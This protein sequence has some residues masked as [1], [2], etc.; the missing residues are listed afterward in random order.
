M[1]LRRKRWDATEVCE[2]LC[3][4]PKQ[5]SDIFKREVARQHLLLAKAASAD[6][7]EL[8]GFYLE[9]IAHLHHLILELEGELIRRRNSGGGAKE[10][11]LAAAPTSA[12]RSQDWAG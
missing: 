5:L 6:E 4:S 10:A 1:P 9:R 2:A 11:T 12:N 8:G 7:I 3:M